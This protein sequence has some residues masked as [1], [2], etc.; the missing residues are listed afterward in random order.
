VSGSLVNTIPQ[1]LGTE[2]LH[3]RTISDATGRHLQRP[4]DAGRRPGMSFK[5]MAVAA[6]VALSM[7]GAPVLAQ[8][9]APLSVVTSVER[10]GATLGHANDLR[11]DHM[12]APRLLCRGHCRHLPHRRQ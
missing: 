10:S 6:T 9:A 11:R 2:Q 4:A 8:S 7:I 12:V 5:G 1:G 3:S